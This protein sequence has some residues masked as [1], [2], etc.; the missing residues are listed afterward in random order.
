MKCFAVFVIAL[1][2]TPTLSQVK[3][4]TI[5]VTYFTQDKIV[6]AADSRGIVFGKNVPPTDSECKIVAV[7]KE[8][9]FISSGIVSYESGGS[10]DLVQAWDNREEIRSAYGKVAGLYGTSRGHVQDVAIEWGKSILSHFSS[11]YLFHRETMIDDAGKENGVPTAA[12]IGGFDAL[13][14]LVLFKMQISFNQFGPNPLG[15]SVDQVMCP[16]SFCPMGEI[17]TAEEFILE[18]SQRAKDEAVKSK[19]FPS[20]STSD[21]DILR[22]MRLV[23]L[24]IADSGLD[25]VGGPIDALELTRDGGF[26]WYARKSNCPEN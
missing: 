2:S 4:G 24:T 14:N 26:R 12:L 15:L 3:H 8:L 10:L 7:N 17:D 6:M 23:D 18:T 20:S 25:D 5:G 22:A 21:Y 1:I 16:N 11:L 13:G 9:V 19:I